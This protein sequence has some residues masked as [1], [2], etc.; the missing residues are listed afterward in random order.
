MAKAVS[1]QRGLAADHTE[2]TLFHPLKAQRSAFDEG[3]RDSLRQ[4]LV[5]WKS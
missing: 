3:S 4:M 5:S 2:I 1:P